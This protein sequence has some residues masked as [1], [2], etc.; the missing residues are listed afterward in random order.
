MGFVTKTTSRFTFLRPN[1]V[2]LQYDGNFFVRA[3]KL[4]ILSTYTC[5][6]FLK[7]IFTLKFECDY[8]LNKIVNISDEMAHDQ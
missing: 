2:Q 7:I 8:V 1:T 6:R 3:T 4:L 5:T